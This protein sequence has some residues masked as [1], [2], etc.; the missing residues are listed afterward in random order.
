MIKAHTLWRIHAPQ[1]T[2][3]QLQRALNMDAFDAAK[4]I[5]LQR[6]QVDEAVAKLE[7]S[8]K[9]RS[10]TATASNTDVRDTVSEVDPS[11]CQANRIAML[12]FCSMKTSPFALA[13]P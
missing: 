4:Q 7:E 13:Y 6:E 5:R 3:T 12:I 2:D 11:A 1:E 9:G 8:K 10:G